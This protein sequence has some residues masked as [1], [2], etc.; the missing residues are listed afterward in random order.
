MHKHT[1]THPHNSDTLDISPHLTRCESLSIVYHSSLLICYTTQCDHYNSIT[2]MMVVWC[3]GACWISCKEGKPPKKH[4]KKKGPP[5]KEKH[6]YGEKG[7]SHGY[8]FPGGRRAPTLAPPPL[9]R[10]GG[11]GAYIR[12]PRN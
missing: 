7:F 3:I 9:W 5:H 8:I 1:F 12:T 2:N 11:G 6:Q 4:K 10:G